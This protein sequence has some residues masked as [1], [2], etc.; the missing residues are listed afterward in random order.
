M[1]PWLACVRHRSAERP[2]EEDAPNPRLPRE[3][4]DAVGE[5]SPAQVWFT[6]NEEKQLGRLITVVFMSQSDTLKP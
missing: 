1:Q 4:Q 3:L 2:D 5:S 6:A